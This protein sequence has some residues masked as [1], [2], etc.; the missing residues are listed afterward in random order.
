MPRFVLPVPAVA[1]LLACLAAPLAAQTPPPPAQTSSDS[2]TR[3]E[4]QRAGSGAFRIL[5][6]VT[7]TTPGTRRYHNTIRAGAT[8]TVH[9]VTDLHT[10]TA[11]QWRVVDGATARGNGHPTAN[12]NDFYIEVD[13]P[14][15]VPRGGG[16]R[17]RIDKTYVDTASYRSDAGDIVFS[18]SLGIAL[19]SV[20]LPPG[21]ELASVNVPSQI[22]VERDGRIKVSFMNAASQAVTYTVR[23]R[24]L[25]ASAAAALAQAA[26]QPRARTNAPATTSNAYDG[27]YVRTDRTFGERAAETRDIVYFLEQP[28]SNAFRLYHDYTETRPGVQAYNNVVRAGS[29]VIDP[30]AYNL[31]TGESLPVSIVGDTVRISFPPVKEN[32]S[33]RL[34]IHETYVDANRY[35]RSGDELVWDRNFGRAR[36]SVVL[37]QGW[38]VTASDMPATVSTREDGRTMLTFW[39][40]RPDGLQVF[41]RART[42]GAPVATSLQGEKLYARPHPEPVA[43]ERAEAA[44]RAAPD[45]VDRMFDVARELERAFRYDDAVTLYSRMIEKAPQ[46]WRGWRFRGH[47]M[48]SLRRFADGARDLERAKQLAPYNFDVSYHL[49]LAYYLLGRFDAAADE[50]LRCTALSNNARERARTVP[51]QRTCMSIAESADTRVAIEEWTYRALRRAG[52]EAEARALLARVTNNLSVSTNAAYYRALLT[53]RN[54]WPADDLLDPLPADGRFET[55]AYGLAVDALLANERERAQF[56]L[57]RIAQDA[58]WPGFGR[59]AAEV[60][61]TRVR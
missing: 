31:D 33:T 60:D 3:Y 8:V 14:R 47:R 61:L 58:H 12:P 53:R 34:R 35:G 20:V 23:A 29:R 59:I 38:F 51:D 24:A 40:A 54:E 5:Y 10:G 17:V 56:L 1:I 36:N 44:L 49:G 48:L 32:A 42:R 19:N 25:P 21:Y 22:D 9:G 41:L 7:A 13:L 11:L 18:R 52:R 55:R 2:Y 45:N 26:S 46:D 28:E 6:D 39:N 30:A 27:S 16:V 37:P 15:A 57:R 4:L 43:L 50:Y